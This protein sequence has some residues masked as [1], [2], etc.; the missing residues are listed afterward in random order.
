MGNVTLKNQPILIDPA[1]SAIDQGW[2][3]SG[4]LAKHS[5]CFSGIITSNTIVLEP[6]KSYI[7]IYEVVE[8]V[9]GGV[10][11]IMGGLNGINRTDIGVYTEQFNIPNGATDTTVK[12]YSDG[13][14]S[15]GLTSVFPVL[16][17][18]ANSITLGFN[19][20]GNKWPTYYPFSVE[21]MLQFTTSLFS[22]KGGGLWRHNV[23]PVRNNFH[24][25]QFDSKI[26]F[27][28]NTE[29]FKDKLWYNMRLDAK[30]N[31]SA[32]RITTA[33]TNQ[34]PNGMETALKTGNFK[35]IDGKLWADILRDKKD[36]N[37]AGETELKSLFKG[38]MMQGGWLIVEMECKD[39]TE[40]SLASVEIYYTEIE[41]SL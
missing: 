38:R 41:R 39:T 5:G 33:K 28:A 9:S 40:A 35:L 31:W 1:L 29:Y 37:F 13:V 7:I 24:G 30:G 3:I 12:F 17:D 11:A 18:A 14:L 6:G 8:R 20:E 10:Y 34:F 27:I 15:V 26:I 22:F 2:E 36:P 32:P 16:E 21:M 19:S 25:E 4:D 23:N